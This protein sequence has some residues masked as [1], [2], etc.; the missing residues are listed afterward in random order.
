MKKYLFTLGL[1]AGLGEVQAVHAQASLLVNL[2]GAG[3]RL[4][5]HAA[6]K[7]KGGLPAAEAPA[8][9]PAATPVAPVATGAPTR[10]QLVLHR[11]PTDQLPKRGATQIT[12]LETELDR[13]HSSLLADS[14]GVVCP[15]AQR[16]VLQHAIMR[17]A[18]AS[19]SWNLQPY[20]Q[21]AAF[22][23]AEDIRR[24]QAAAVAK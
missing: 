9:A 10:P 23:V 12:A 11:T 5:V 2:I 4:G 6:R 13:C 22:Y 7:P 18:Q 17:V 16:T 14:T 19:P 3:V 21:E 24:Q 8:G 15:L 1:L 20:Q